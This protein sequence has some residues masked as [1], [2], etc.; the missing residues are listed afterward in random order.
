MI[1]PTEVRPATAEELESLVEYLK[2]DMNFFPDPEG[3]DEA[4]MLVEGAC[5]AVFP[6]YM[7]GCPGYSGALL[8]AVYDGDPGYAETYTL[9]DGRL[10][11]ASVRQPCDEIN[12]TLGDIL[13]ACSDHNR[14]RR[15]LISR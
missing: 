1:D 2:P 8:V 11:R 3:T 6:R 14:R 12:M 13:R 9:R 4:R 15:F 7:T 10:E 5:V